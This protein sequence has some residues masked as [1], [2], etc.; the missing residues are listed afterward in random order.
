MGEKYHR[1][2]VHGSSEVLMQEGEWG[3]KEEGCLGWHRKR[4]W[5]EHQGHS[6]LQS[7]VRPRRYK[8]TDSN[9]AGKLLGV[10]RKG[11][12]C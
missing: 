12:I 1:A 2:R 8:D 4:E 10:S 3:V 6:R 5:R 11:A 7:V 9:G